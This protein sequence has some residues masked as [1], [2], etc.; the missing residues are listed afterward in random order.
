MTE[1][2]GGKHFLQTVW[3][4]A[5]LLGQ[6]P[7]GCGKHSDHIPAE[8]GETVTEKQGHGQGLQLSNFKDNI[9]CWEVWLYEVIIHI[10]FITEL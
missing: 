3:V 2:V 1:E 7:L 6:D 10:Q 8:R 5:V 9:W 4:E